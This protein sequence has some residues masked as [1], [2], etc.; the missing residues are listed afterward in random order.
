MRRRLRVR[1]LLWTLA[2]LAVCAA[3]VH[4]LHNYQVRR[5]AG[6]I[7]RQA[8]HAVEQEQYPQALTLLTHYLTCVPGDVEAQAKLAVVQDRLART[9]PQKVRA[10]ALLEQVL[11]RA[12]QRAD[13]RPRAV[14]LA[15]ELGRTD[16]AVRH[17]RLL[18]AAAPDDAGLEVRLAEC[19]EQGGDPERAAAALRRAIAKDPAHLVAHARLADLLRYHLDRAAEVGPLLD[20]LVAANPRLAGAWLLRARHHR[21][22]GDAAAANRDLD[23]ALRLGPDDA[24][25]LF[26]GAEAAQAARRW[27]EA[28]ALLG[29]AVLV[30]PTRVE[31]YRALAALQMRGGRKDD[32]QACLRRGL[33]WV[34]T[35]QELRF[36][37]ADLLVETGDLAGAEK[38]LA[39]LRR[40]R[41]A[42]LV[43]EFLRGRL[44]QGRRE[45]VEA[46]ALLEGL[47]PR[48]AALP[49]WLC[50]A[51][52]RLGECY[53]ELGET[54]P[55]LAAYRRAVKEQPLAPDARFGLAR[56]LVRAGSAA[57][58][59][60]ELEA[61]ANSPDAPPEA[62]AWWARAMVARHGA[63]AAEGADW[64]RVER[65]LAQ[66]ERE[67]PGA[68]LVAVAWAEVHLA[69]RHPAGA[70]AVLRLAL[71]KHPRAEL[72]WVAL[73]DL[74]A[75]RGQWAEARRALAAGRAA[76]GSGVALRMA[77][78]RLLELS[79]WGGDAAAAKQAVPA[80]AALAGQPREPLTA[81]EQAR[82]LHEVARALQRLGG[83]A[84]AARVWQ[85]LA[86]EQPRELGS[87]LALFDLAVKAGDA[88][89]AAALAEEVRRVEGEGGPLW[90]AC[91]A[92]ALI[93]RS[94][95]GDAAALAPARRLL[96]EAAKAQPGWARLAWLEGALAE[97]AGDLGRALDH[98]VR[99]LEAGER[100]PGLALRVARLLA[101]R[102][103]YLEADQALRTLPDAVLL[104]DQALREL[105][106]RVAVRT[107]NPKRA[108]ALAREAVPAEVRDYREQLWLARVL[109]A[110]GHDAEAEV[111]LRRTAA[112]SKGIPDVWVELVRH[113]AWQRLLPEAEAALAEA[114]KELPAGRRALAQARGLDVLGDA[115]KA[116]AVYLK[117]VKER[118]DD[119]PVLAE[120]AAFYRRQEQWA[121]AAAVLRKLLDP[122]TGAPDEVLVEA[123]RELALVL[124]EQGAAPDVGLALL[125]ENERVVGR[126]AADERARAAVLAADPARRAEAVRRFEQTL[127]AGP[128][129]P[130]E[131]FALARLYA[132][133][134]EAARSG[135]LLADL[136]ADP[137]AD[138]RHLGYHVHR[139]LQQN[140]LDGAAFYLNRL[141]R[142]A[143]RAA[144]TRQLQAL[145]LEA[146]AAVPQP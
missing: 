62:W 92:E 56:A 72:L 5:N 81:G 7:L 78:V 122:Q 3:A 96:D 74:A 137:Q 63:D 89:A 70:E 43:A 66:A 47:R 18:I 9:R 127:D 37:H 41:G 106:L 51:E 145:L 50:Q 40:Q 112:R 73:V 11:R 98:Y 27:D 80:L 120:L 26:A 115:D 118:P 34:P 85:G 142:T 110:A 125:A 91:A 42:V 60:A 46:A 21:E 23:E 17:V 79:A 134:G 10:L 144:R 130:D 68:P 15:L 29:R 138:A 99:A 101:E 64:Q 102:R 69:R 111:V 38:E 65:V 113:L 59:E 2:G 100:Q 116:E 139:L 146:R 128:L 109:R 129:E 77:E 86:R 103:R 107:P 76:I 1:L 117:M 13:L 104:R 93:A 48:L 88:P 136:L 71:A 57:E 87:R 67:A 24:D 123:R 108:V 95:P 35:A 49:E 132:A 52:V 32:A 114:Q 82:W 126:R 39:A 97:R 28:R 54:E 53:E 75:Q 135:E 121:R 84:E 12:P 90:R 45:W 61:L 141:E 4:A 19:H 31:F 83:R 119:C 105:A 58:A 22:R 33:E 36:H 55:A 94:R 6:T 14:A 44:L 8:D 30:E 20:E 133:Q 25:V 16:D 124:A 131:Q 140:D 143:P